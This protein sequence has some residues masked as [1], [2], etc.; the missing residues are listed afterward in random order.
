MRGPYVVGSY[1]RNENQH[2]FT[3]D[4]W[5]RTGDVGCI[6][7]NGYMR[8]VDRTKDLIKSGGE[9]ISSVDIET[10]LMSHHS[11]AECAVVAM[12][13]ARFQER[14]L[15]VLVLRRGSPVPSKEEL[16]KF[17]AQKIA[18]WWIPDEFVVVDAIP[19]VLLIL[20]VSCYAFAT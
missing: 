15:A 10:L 16:S 5:F 6:D 14:P 11:V 2:A 20:P 9:W 13:H 4:G 12:P 1:F 8:L 18:K 19:K 17:L 7:P 3:S